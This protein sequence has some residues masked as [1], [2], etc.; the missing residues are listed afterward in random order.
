MLPYCGQ[1]VYSSFM[2]RLTTVE[3]TVAGTT[4]TTPRSAA[5]RTPLVLLAVSVALGPLATDAYVPSLPT[6]AE[7]LGSR[8]SVVQLSVMACLLAL[9]VGQL[10]AG[11]WSDV[12][13][14]RPVLL[15]GVGLFVAGSVVAGVSPS[16][17]MFVAS[18]AAVGLG[19]AF[20]L[21][22]TYAIVRDGA[23]GERTAAAFSTLL[24][25]AGTTPVFAPLAGTAVLV[26]W[27]W[28]AIFLLM[29]LIGAA[30]LVTLAF[31][32]PE[33]L[34]VNPPHT[35]G[36]VFRRIATDPGFVRYALSNALVFGVMFIYV[37]GGPFVLQRDYGLSPVQFGVVF[38][39]NAV[40]LVAAAQVSGRASSRVRPSLLVVSGALSALVGGVV[41]TIGAVSDAGVWVVLAG[42]FIAVS[43]VG[44]VLPQAT[45]LALA[46]YGDSAG[47]AS[48]VFGALQYAAAAL[49]AA[50]A[51]LLPITGGTP[52]GVAMVAFAAAATAAF[53][54]FHPRISTSKELLHD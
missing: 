13:G 29:A 39:V 28:R 44:L 47:A 19:G 51:G 26:T 6:I 1:S 25:V 12:V 18:L 46:D 30:L 21:V 31:G 22:S 2:L 24:L 8:A 32:M 10:A 15:S 35:A 54:V 48:A 42:M 11:P 7:D 45:A 38:A 40:G 33:T 27:G 5:K 41:V 17:V 14:R 4:S 52:T 9:A 16:A 53:F 36:R 23:R 37:T 20:A 34:R 50:V 3:K 49:A 43:A